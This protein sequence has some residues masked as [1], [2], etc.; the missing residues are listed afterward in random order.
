MASSSLHIITNVYELAQH[1][2][3][4]GPIV[5]NSGALTLPPRSILVISVQAPMELNIKHL[6]QL[7]AIDDLPSGIIPLSVDHK[8]GHK[9]P[10][11]L[12]IP[13]LNTEHNIVHIPRNT[14]TGKLNQ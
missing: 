3:K 13:L 9:Y 6:Y 12:K 11:L 8:I 2:P 5:Q 10:K 14:I 1:H 7:D 4:K